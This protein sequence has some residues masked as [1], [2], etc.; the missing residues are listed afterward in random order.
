MQR[1]KDLNKIDFDSIP[2]D[3]FWNTGEEKELKMH[4]IHSYPAKFPAFI[5]NKA[6]AYAKKNNFKYKRIED[7]FCG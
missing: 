7:I 1:I 3:S 5:T 6:I 2:I 4:R